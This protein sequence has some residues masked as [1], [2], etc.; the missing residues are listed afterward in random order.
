MRSDPRYRAC[1]VPALA[2]AGLFL[3]DLC[4]GPAVAGS[5][6]PISKGPEVSTVGAGPYLGPSA[7][8]LA[9]LSAL[10]SVPAPV[11]RQVKD[12]VGSTITLG[13][14][15]VLTQAELAKIAGLPQIVLHLPDLPKL[16]IMKVPTEGIPEL[17]AREREKRAGELQNAPQGPDAPKAPRSGR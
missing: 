12:P 7:T 5:D 15:S 8:E 4:S 9:K 3:T 10:E 2:L 1:L 14:A 16:G 6:L 17:T 13:S 11:P